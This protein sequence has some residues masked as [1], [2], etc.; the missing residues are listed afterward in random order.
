V[1]IDDTDDRFER[2]HRRPSPSRGSFDDN[3]KGPAEV[4]EVDPERDLP[5]SVYA[6][7]DSYWGFEAPG[8]TSH[9]GACAHCSAA[10]QHATFVKGTD[11]RSSRPNITP[12]LLIQ[13]SA[14]NGLSK[15][16]AFAL[17]PRR[18]RLH[19]AVLLHYDRKMGALDPD[20]LARL[21]GEL[22]RLFGQAPGGV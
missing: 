21:R 22:T 17:A 3:G 9:P 1:A 19:K 14:A 2:W 13:P 12:I 10:G 15:E 20:D 4:T 11:V 6:V 5:G 7:P 8:R 18:L 16:T